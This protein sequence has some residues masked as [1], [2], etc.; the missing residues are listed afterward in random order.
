M[1][2]SMRHSFKK[3]FLRLFF[4]DLAVQFAPKTRSKILA[5]YLAFFLRMKSEKMWVFY[6]IGVASDPSEQRR[7][8]AIKD[9]AAAMN[10][11]S[12]ARND[13]F[14]ALLLHIIA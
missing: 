2:N 12:W 7:H 14:R 8:A 4:E 11:C 13:I 3:A 9:L 1:S 6:V 10:Q 5:G